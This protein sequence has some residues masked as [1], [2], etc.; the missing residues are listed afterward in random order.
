MKQLW[1]IAVIGALVVTSGC[2]RIEVTN[3]ASNAANTAASNTT[4]S[5]ESNPKSDAPAAAT[6]ETAAVS[7]ATPTDAYKAA[8]EY[9]K[10]KD[11]EGLK[12]VM[13]KDVLEFLTE[14]GKAEKK[15]LDDML[16][17]MC[18]KPQ[19]ATN[20]TRNLKIQGDAAT[21]EYP[22]AEG[23][24]WKTMDFVKEGNDWK[25]TIPKAPQK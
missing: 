4:A 1:F 23:K 6:K 3:S 24:D 12:K 13:S 16:R 19:A 7:L 22:D 20:M 21:L 5:G 25:M 8:Y 18:E 2:G 11:I 14:I 17:E 10:N 9:R 15:S